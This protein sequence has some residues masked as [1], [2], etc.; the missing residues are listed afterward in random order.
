MSDNPLQY[1]RFNQKISL[2]QEIVDTETGEILLSL[3]S[4][5]LSL[6][7][8]YFAIV[9]IRF[10]KLLRENRKNL[11]VTLRT[12]SNVRGTNELGFVDDSNCPF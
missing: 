12:F 7:V 4:S 9:L 1:V 6:N 2:K 5:V 11:Q 8:K 3:D 10:I